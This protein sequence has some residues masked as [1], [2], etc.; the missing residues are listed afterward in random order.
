MNTLLLNFNFYY[1]MDHYKYVGVAR[2]LLRLS[3]ISR[4]I[5]DYITLLH[6]LNIAITVSNKFQFSAVLLQLFPFRSALQVEN[7]QFEMRN[8]NYKFRNFI[9]N[10]MH[11][12]PQ[13]LF[14]SQSK[15][16]LL[17]VFIVEL[18]TFFSLYPIESL[19]KVAIT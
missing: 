4:C 14:E 10:C 9:A 19:T 5:S 7:F 1:I 12:F 6:H 8:R 16:S 2:R 13:S 11:L 17:H 15:F 3:M 18:C